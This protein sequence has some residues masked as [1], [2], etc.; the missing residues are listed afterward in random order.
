LGYDTAQDAVDQL[1]TYGLG[2][3]D[4]TGVIIG[5]TANH[6]QRSLRQTYD[7]ILFFHVTK[8]TSGLTG[9]Y[10]TINL[11]MQH[12]EES[13]TEIRDGYAKVFPDKPFEYFFLDDYFN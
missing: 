2:S 1:I 7:P 8:P 13:L 10:I 6:H 5:V 11:N 4:W 9:Q 3:A 12:P